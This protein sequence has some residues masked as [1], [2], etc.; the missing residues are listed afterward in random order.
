MREPGRI[1]GGKCEDCGLRSWCF[2]TVRTGRRR[3]WLCWKRYRAAAS[4][5]GGGLTSDDESIII[6]DAP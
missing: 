1:A 3:C 5:P 2:I 6:V 4:A